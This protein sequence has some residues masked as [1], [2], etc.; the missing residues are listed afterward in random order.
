AGDG[1]RSGSAD[2]VDDDLVT[3]DQA[4]L[5]TPVRIGRGPLRE[6]LADGLEIG[7]DPTLDR[8]HGILLE[9]PAAPVADISKTYRARRIPFARRWLS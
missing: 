5:R 9:A 1:I 2:Q 4:Q 3:D 6:T 7:A 8:T